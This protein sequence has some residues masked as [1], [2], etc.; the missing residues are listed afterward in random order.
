[1]PIRFG[2]RRKLRDWRD[3]AREIVIIVVGVLIALGASHVAEQ[4]N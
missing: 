4:W 1:M 2:S 3:F